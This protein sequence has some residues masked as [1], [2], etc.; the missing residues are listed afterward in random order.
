MEYFLRD[1]TQVY[2]AFP[3]PSHEAADRERNRREPHC[4]AVVGRLTLGERLQGLVSA[5]E[6]ARVALE[7]GVDPVYVNSM[8]GQAVQR[9]GSEH[10]VAFDTL[11]S[12]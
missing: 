8:L 3:Y 10:L 4:W 11:P 9:F 7:Q 1:E 12:V 2:W 5:I 6:H